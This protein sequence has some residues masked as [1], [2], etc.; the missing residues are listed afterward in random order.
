MPGFAVLIRSRP[1]GSL[2]DVRQP[3]PSLSAGPSVWATVLAGGIGTRFWPLSTARRPK[4]LLPLA[5]PRPLVVDALD[6]IE[7]L[8]PPD[9]VRILTGREMVAPLQEATGLGA[10]SF[11]VE[12]QSKGTGPALAWAARQIARVDPQ[13]VQVSLHAD[14]VI[15]PRD[16]FRDVIEAGVRLADRERR[17]VVLAAKPDRPETG[18]GYVELGSSLDGAAPCRAWKVRSFVEK[19]DP[20]TASRYVAD[21]YRWN[22]GSFI[23]PVAT[24]LEEVAAR[25]PEFSAALD[26]APDARTFFRRA[27][28][29]AV[30][31]AVMERSPRVAA[32]E[33]L[34]R[35]DD[36]GSW[37]ALARTRPS[38][39]TGNV[40]SGDVHLAEAANNIAVAD[41][42]RVVLL[43]VEDLLV[44]RTDEV[45]LV[46]PRTKSPE[47]GRYVKE[48]DPEAS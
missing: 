4:Q 44:V 8:V 21:G 17:L 9:K 11:W 35:W 1:R 24:F 39:A 45:T 41:S 46:M 6:R 18:F 33:A 2:S 13:A 23:W 20:A 42:G 3:F 40:S 26:G 29:V 12:P 28:S 32:L 16:A 31:V 19:P 22:T 25:A 34:F 30:D 27:E 48:I 36:M 38:D 14:A 43:G 5:G 7:G 10:E 15:Q 47:L 37:E